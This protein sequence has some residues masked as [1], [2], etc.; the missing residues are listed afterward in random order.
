[1]D[2][3][4]TG[5]TQIGIAEFGILV[6]Y[7]AVGTITLIIFA[8]R[9]LK[10]KAPKKTTRRLS[11]QVG[12]ADVVDVEQ[13]GNNAAMAIKRLLLFKTHG[14]MIDGEESTKTGKGNKRKHW[15]TDVKKIKFK[16]K[17]GAGNFGEVWVGTWMHSTVAIKTVLRSMASNTEFV[18][19][20]IEEINL[21]SELNH[22]NIVMFLGACIQPPSICLILE[23][24]EEGNLMEFLQSAKARD[25]QVSMHLILKMALDIARGI[26]Y[27]HEKMQIIQR[28]IKGRNVLVDENL[29]AKIADFG[30]SRIRN[31][32]DDQ[33]LTA[34]GT[35][36]WTAPEVVRMEDYTEKVD[37]YSFGVVLWE[38]IMRNEPY[39]GEGG[40]Q[41]AY[42][43]AE[44]GLRP[45]VPQ[46]APE[47][48]TGLMEE[49]WADRPDD[50]PNFGEILGRLFQM[51]KDESNPLKAAEFYFGR[52]QC[53]LNP[54]LDKLLDDSELDDGLFQEDFSALV[55]HRKVSQ[56]TKS[57]DSGKILV[58]KGSTPKLLSSQNNIDII[59][60]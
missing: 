10:G 59:N 14:G 5:E 34:C 19:K 38:L 27:L 21:M 45:P 52:K 48:Y 33:G 35:P 46:F 16:K 39:E 2:S 56:S 7:V 41:I 43:A 40:I 9:Y 32:K 1:M 6:F 31:T 15:E 60:N 11:T 26:K 42:A 47:R 25:I 17:I 54:E 22:P 55:H 18:S 8:V 53:D 3:C 57:H 36:A 37:V 58:N 29:N 28:D 49:C 13:T 23:Y 4:Q 44:Q 12:P 20:F 50:R 24:C 51:M 30:L